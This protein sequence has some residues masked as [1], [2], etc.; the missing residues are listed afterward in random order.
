VEEISHRVINEYAEAIAVLSLAAV[1]EIDPRSKEA[2]RSAAVR[3]RAFA[4]AH[5]AL[6]IPIARDPISVPIY[7]AQVCASITEAKLVE[8]GIGLTIRSD[9]ISLEP[10]RCWRLG[11]I[12]SELVTN[13][14]RHGLLGKPGNICVEI[15]KN[16]GW[17]CCNVSDNGHGMNNA[18]PGRGH[19]I[20]QA[21]V[22]ELGG[23]I[24]WHSA[25]IGCLVQLE[26]PACEAVNWQ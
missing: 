24:E 2:L 10:S 15:A 14:A 7:I 23:M 11:L 17:V 9:E 8:R 12:V 18:E 16:S 25:P 22:A 3:L 21:I 20:V 6:R 5:R 4:E 26:F 19:G 13:A 1:S